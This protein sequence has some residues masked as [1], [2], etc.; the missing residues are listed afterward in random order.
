MS[1][2]IVNPLKKPTPVLSPAVKIDNLVYTSGQVGLNPE[3]G[4]LAGT[5]IED[6][7]KQVMENIKLLLEA[8]GSSMEKTIKCLVFITDMKYFQEMNEVYR[9]YFEKD[10]PARSCVEVAALANPDLIVEI[11]A[12]AGI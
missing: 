6:Q 1:R 3:T 7:T 5:S 4:E 9:S 8:A 10:P 11:E 12:I 2:E